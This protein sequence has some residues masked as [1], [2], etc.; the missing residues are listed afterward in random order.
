MSDLEVRIVELKPMR[1][2]SFLG[3]GESPETLAWEKLMDWARPRGLLD[4]PEKHRLFGFNNPNPSPGSPNYGY[5][6]WIAVESDREAEADEKI[7]DFNGGL[8]AVTR[9]LVPTGKYVVISATWKK[10]IAWQEDS[11]YQR[12]THQW[13]EEMLPVSPPDTEFTLDLY[14]PIAE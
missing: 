3:F 6:A 12:G 1:V 9:C 7:L 11:Q 2:A 14:L 5:E 4:D 8:Y 10:L 13:L